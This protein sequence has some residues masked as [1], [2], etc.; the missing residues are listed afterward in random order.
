[1]VGSLLPSTHSIISIGEKGY[2]RGPN[3]GLRDGFEVEVAKR[4]RR[5]PLAR[6]GCSSRGET[7]MV[8]AR[9]SSEEEVDG[10]RRLALP[11]LD[12]RVMESR[13]L[14]ALVVAEW[15]ERCGDQNK[16][17]NGDTSFDPHKEQ[18]EMDCSETRVATMGDAPKEIMRG[19]D[20]RNLA[21]C[22]WGF[23]CWMRCD[24][25]GICW[26]SSRG[27]ATQKVWS[28]NVRKNS[29]WEKK[30]GRAGALL[31]CGCRVK[32]LGAWNLWTGTQGIG[33]HTD[34]QTQFFDTAAR[35]EE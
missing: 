4:S 29:G 7:E 12:A 20:T 3:R 10:S 28:G 24:A 16:D 21:V 30:S 8:R 17:T 9:G 19:K 23:Q 1:M 32:A 35:R 13:C 27:R 14:E 2:R 18:C 33:P 25:G 34:D 22:G 6:E 31:F 26:P 5:G 15:E 11:S